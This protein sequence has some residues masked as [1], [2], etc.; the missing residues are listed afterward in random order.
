MISQFLFELLPAEAAVRRALAVPLLGQ[1]GRYTS[2]YTTTSPL[3]SSAP[4][5]HML[6]CPDLPGLRSNYKNY[7]APSLLLREFWVRF[8]QTNTY[9]SWECRRA[10]AWRGACLGQMVRRPLSEGRV[11]R[12]NHTSQDIPKTNNR[13]RDQEARNQGALPFSSWAFGHEAITTPYSL[14]IQRRENKHLVNIWFFLSENN[15][16]PRNSYIWSES[17]IFLQCPSCRPGFKPHIDYTFFF[18]LIFIFFSFFFQL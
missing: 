8:A 7:H 14:F 11:L 1:L 5:F 3:I 9:G 13:P 4:T 12:N 10:D 6:S 18:F 2:W 16:Q 17:T 15:S